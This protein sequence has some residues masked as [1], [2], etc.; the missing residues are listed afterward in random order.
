[1]P[2]CSLGGMMGAQRVAYRR[3]VGEALLSVWEHLVSLEAVLI[4]PAPPLR[5]RACS[6]EGDGYILS[7]RKSKDPKAIHIA[8]GSECCAEALSASLLFLLDLNQGP[9][10]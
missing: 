9:S 5:T 10:D 6:R 4:R 8:L 7:P 3:S 1:M 2:V